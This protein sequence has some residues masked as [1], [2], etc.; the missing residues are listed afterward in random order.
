MPQ[1]FSQFGPYLVAALIVFAVYRRLRRSFGR[2]PLRQGRMVF[3]IAL[4]SVVAV[5]LA[6]T[7]LRSSAFAAAAVIGLVAGVLLAVFGAS[8][9]RFESSGA[10][11]FY[12]P[13]T[14]TGI[15]VSLLFVGRVAYRLLQAYGIAH[16]A[17]AVGA[18]AGAAGYVSSPLTLGLFYVLAGYYV[19]YLSFILWKSKHL[20]PGEAQEVDLPVGTG[21]GRAPIGPASTGRADSG[22][23]T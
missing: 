21:D 9:T 19:Y 6:P 18:P 17:R 11:R 4:L 8:R 5:L 22:T 2:Q 3:R 14:Y 16:G 13:H 7:A 12:V 15:A 1:D 23:P 20:K 10:Q